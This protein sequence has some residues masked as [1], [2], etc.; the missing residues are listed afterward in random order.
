VVLVSQGICVYAFLPFDQYEITNDKRRIRNEI[1]P[2]LVIRMGASDIV[3]FIP[4]D[5]KGV[6][7]RTEIVT[8]TNVFDE[9]SFLPQ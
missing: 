8:K 6:K 9:I 3:E 1:L 5:L 2:L 7:S 4:R